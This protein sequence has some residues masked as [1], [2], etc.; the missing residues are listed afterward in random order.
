M[1]L[2]RFQSIF[3]VPCLLLSLVASAV[4]DDTLASAYG[5]ILRGDYEAGRAVIGRLRESNAPAEKVQ[6]VEGWLKSF[7]EMQSSREALWGKTFEWNVEHARKAID[8]AAALAKGEAEP[9][10]TAAKRSLAVARKTYLALSFVAQAAAYAK[11]V[12]AFGKE[13]WVQALRDRALTLAEEF[14]E[15][16]DWSKAYR[17]HILLESIYPKDEA[18]KSKREDAGRHARLEVIF[19][20]KKDIDRRL[21]GVDAALLEQAIRVVNDFYYKEPDFKAMM[22]AA[23]DHLETLSNTTKLYDKADIFAGIANGRSREHFLAKLDE[24]RKKA[25]ADPEFDAND[26]IRAFRRIRDANKVSVSLPES[27]LVMEFTEGALTKLDQFTSMIWPVDAPDFDKQMTGSFCGVGIQLGVDEMTGRLKAVTPLENSPALRAGIQPDDLIIAVNGTDTTGWSTDRAVREITGEE[28]SPVELTMLRPSTGE[29]L[30]YPLKREPIQITSV[31]GVNRI[32]GDPQGKW[33]FLLDKTAGIAYIKMTGF[34][35]DTNDELHAALEAAKEQGMRGLVLDLRYNPGGLLDVAVAT[36]SEFVQKG[37][38]VSTK[39]RAERPQKLDVLQEASFADLP[40][41]VLINDG[42]ASA[43]EILSGALQ[44][45]NRAAVLGERTFGKGSVQKVLGLDRGGMGFFRNDKPSARI[46]LTTALYYL[47]NGRSP[48]KQPGAEVWGVDPDW[49]IKLAPKETLKVIES[50]RKAYIIHNEKT[51]A[52]K[53]ID[54]EARKKQLESVKST[55]ATEDSE[56]KED[57]QLL[58]AADIELLRSDPNKAPDVD[59]QLQTALLQLRVKL[60]G[61][62]P[63]PRQIAQKSAEPDNKR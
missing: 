31:R 43:S 59:P 48:H 63:W 9:D 4:A 58:S 47:P 54:E 20:D 24:E 29:K 5:A 37:A 18:L 23:I 61:D 17:F 27:L 3:L 56:T 49:E 25:E 41:V 2:R 36:V 30:V 16:S 62:L 22:A 40:L 15:K 50:E 38:V 52:E 12:D 11:D 35:Q 60:A 42:S 39:G 34:T 8:E 32:D 28:G 19:S 53:A 26:M 44:D 51:D 7:Q 33:N 46:K 10:L 13:E 45:H 21:E 1:R 57:E 6:Q 55:P 14:G